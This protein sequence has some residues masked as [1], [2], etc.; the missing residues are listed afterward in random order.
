M[1]SISRNLI[2][3]HYTNPK[4]PHVCRLHIFT[5]VDS[6]LVLISGDFSHSASRFTFNYPQRYGFSFP[7]CTNNHLVLGISNIHSIMKLSISFTWLSI[8][9]YY[10][11]WL[12]IFRF[13]T[14]ILSH[15]TP[16]PEWLQISCFGSFCYKLNS[17][18]LYAFI[19]VCVYTCKRM[20]TY[21]YTHR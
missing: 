14:P 17:N 2:P 8:I 5:V 1:Q 4:F 19:H 16:V 6:V 9:K 13:C 18:Q 10:F 3:A 7:Y 21:I 11:T 12:L 20:Y 15:N